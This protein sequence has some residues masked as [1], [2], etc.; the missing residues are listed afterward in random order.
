VALLDRETSSK[1]LV[2][3]TFCF[4]NGSVQRSRIGERDLKIVQLDQYAFDRSQLSSNNDHT[5]EYSAPERHISEPHGGQL[6]DPW[7]VE[8]SR[9]VRAELHDRITAPIYPVVIRC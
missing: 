2:A 1:M 6:N 5:Q 9:Q 7:S 3:P 8:R 4:A